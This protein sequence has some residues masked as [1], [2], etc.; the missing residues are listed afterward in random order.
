VGHP[1][2]RE[3]GGEE[4]D[5]ET[6]K[7]IAGITIFA[8]GLWQYR[9][10]QTWKRLEFVAQQVDAFFSNPSVKNVLIML[11]WDERQINL[12][13]SANKEITHI[14]DDLVAR[15]LRLSDRP[16]SFSVEEAAIREEFDVFLGFLTRFE[17]FIESGLVEPR[18]FE[19]YLK[20]WFE[21]LSGRR[22]SVRS[23]KIRQAFWNYVDGYDQ[24]SVRSLLSRYVSLGPKLEKSKLRELMKSLEGDN[25]D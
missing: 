7:V 6:L 11:E 12:F 25:Q 4:V 17:H 13:R 14:V 21:I 19:P 5:L 18:D 24:N 3:E 15:S 16:E 22:G 9:R 8:A 20:Y 1:P 23:G 2:E 10:A